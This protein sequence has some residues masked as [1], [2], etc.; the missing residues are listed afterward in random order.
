MNQIVSNFTGEGA[1][2]GST[3]P[4]PQTVLNPGGVPETNPTTVKKYGGVKPK[5]F[6]TFKAIIS[7]DYEEVA[8]LRLPTQDEVKN[9]GKTFVWRPFHEA[10]AEAGPLTHSVL[11]EMQ[12]HLK[13][14]KKYCY[15]DS[16]IQYFLPGDVAVDS[17]QH[18]LDGTIVVRGKF[19]QDL[20]HPLL[21]D[22][23]AR[24]SGDIDPPD[25]LA[26]HS[27]EHCAT[28]FITQPVEITIPELIPNFDEFDH[29]IRS[30][31]P[32]RKAQPAGSI[33][34]YTGKTSHAAVGATIAG[35]RLWIRVIE[36]DREVIGALEVTDCY[37]SVYRKVHKPQAA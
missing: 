33:A 5:K 35:W 11:Q 9:D 25:Y 26:Y 21:H 22:M 16:K 30:A 18:H 7:Q 10:L 8:Q 28:E 1:Y 31:N 15:V 37:K 13:R 4:K 3:K 12:K 20:G 19:A 27:Y 6:D 29:I 17:Q 14:K 34:S 36:T 32:I 2:H 23:R 24:L